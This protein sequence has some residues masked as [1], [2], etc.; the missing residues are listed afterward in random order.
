MHLFF[1]P[2]VCLFSFAPRLRNGSS[3]SVSRRIWR[4]ATGGFLASLL[5]LVPLSAAQLTVSWDD[6]SSTELGFKVERSTNGSTFS[7]IAVVGANKTSYI[8]SSV[9]SATTYWYRVKAYDLLRAS[10][11]SNVTSAKTPATTATSSSSTPSTSGSTTTVQTPG[12]LKAFTARAI[13]EFG[14][15]QSLIL[16]FTVAGASKSILLRGIGPGL[17]PYTSSKVLPDPRMKLNAGSLLVSTNDNWG[18]S[19]TLISTFQRVGAFAIPGY[20]KDAVLLRYLGANSY[21][22]TVNG[23]YSGLAQTE[24]YDADTATNPTGRISKLAVRASV[25]TGTG[26]LVSGFV[27]AGQAPLKLLVRAIGPSLTGVAATTLQ[28]PQLSIHRGSTLIG[29]NDNWGGSSTLAAAFTKA[30]A[31][32]LPSSS[33]D[34]ALLVT[35]SPGTYSATVSGVSSTSGVARL[36]VYTV[37]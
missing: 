18:G 29:H 37:P 20:S 5:P 33:K 25:R 3:L 4:F 16:D 10:A 2:S 24:I 31:P 23:A 13:T 34:S 27:V 8:D 7:T 26:V 11:Y 21:K 17:D 1:P 35:L 9:V 28:N 22:S 32:S 15:P 36:E 12:R 30:G 19:T 14:D 6:N